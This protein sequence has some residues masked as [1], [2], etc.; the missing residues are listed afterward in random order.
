MEPINKKERN[1]AIWKVIG[2]FALSL[3]LALLPFY[4]TLTQ[5]Q[6]EKKSLDKDLQTANKQLEFQQVYLS[7]KIAKAY[8]M[9]SQLDDPE[10]NHHVINGNIGN[11][12]SDMGIKIDKQQNAEDWQKKMYEN[13]KKTYS[14]YHK[15]KEE[16]RER[17]K[18][19]E[20]NDIEVEK[21]NVELQRAYNEIKDLKAETRNAKSSDRELL[22]CQTKLN[23][24]K[25]QY[26]KM[27]KIVLTQCGMS[28]PD[29]KL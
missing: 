9:L 8:D 24:V 29:L 4:R 13:I 10:A 23:K 27:Q 22:D 2:L 18:E 6:T 3:I 5:P 14:E 7:P 17:R 28:V 11:L 15:D 19:G 26:K 1:R 20:G 12:I 16:L 21:G 25:T